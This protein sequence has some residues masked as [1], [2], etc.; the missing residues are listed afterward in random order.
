MNTFDVHSSITLARPLVEVFDF[1]ADA[2]NLQTLT[3]PWVHFRILSELPIE[4]Q[5]GALI[6]YRIRVRGWPLRWRTRISAWEP[7]YR[8]VDEQ[9]RGP[10]ARWVHEHR[11]REVGGNTVCEDHV[12]YA[13]IGGVVIQK[14]FVER[15]V[16]RIFQY[17]RQ[18]M[19][20]IFGSVD[21]DD[22]RAA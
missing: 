22:L 6:D 20:A 21:A 2:A 13:P 11:F 12:N 9:I 8:F 16:E 19:T 15:D 1:F 3:P 5:K 4:M 14:L 10:Y 17:R 18:R 7:P